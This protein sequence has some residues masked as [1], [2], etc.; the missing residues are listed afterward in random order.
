MKILTECV[1]KRGQCRD[2]FTVKQ[3]SILNPCFSNETLLDSSIR[4]W[5][6]WAINWWQLCLLP[7]A[8]GRSTGVWW[9]D[10]RTA[11]VTVLRKGEDVGRPV[12]ICRTVQLAGVLYL[13]VFHA[14]WSCHAWLSVP[15]RADVSDA[16]QQGDLSYRWNIFLVW[17]LSGATALPLS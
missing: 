8:L 2:V 14:S 11:A 17:F 6:R 5:A 12:A 1:T 9:M 10:T 7:P 4:L 15:T 13:H 16:P 3:A